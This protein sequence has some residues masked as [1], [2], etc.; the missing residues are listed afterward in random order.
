MM[1]R[2]HCSLPPSPTTS[3]QLPLLLTER[4]TTGTKITW[5]GDTETIDE[6]QTDRIYSVFIHIPVQSFETKT[7]FV[8]KCDLHLSFSL[9]TLKVIFQP[10]NIH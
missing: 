6:E 1:G 7:R 2:H 4:Q 8:C 10:C 9:E 5:V 3:L